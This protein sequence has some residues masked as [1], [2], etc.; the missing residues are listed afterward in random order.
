M[1]ES[2]CFK[3]LHAKRI[4]RNIVYLVED[5]RRSCWKIVNHSSI[6][7]I[8]FRYQLIFVIL[9]KFMDVGSKGNCSFPNTDHHFSINYLKYRWIQLSLFI[10][11][12]S[13]I[14]NVLTNW[15][16]TAISPKKLD[17]LIQITHRIS[18]VLQSPTHREYFLK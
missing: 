6:D 9:K 1:F 11:A 10:S 17:V 14:S 4:L 16:E 8:L 7:K 15:V 2:V 5:T 18:C 13:S 12:V 3:H